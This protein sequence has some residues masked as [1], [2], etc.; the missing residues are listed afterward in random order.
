MTY[1]ISFKNTITQLM[2]I[3]IIFGYYMVIIWSNYHENQT[4]HYQN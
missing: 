2:A 4:Y 3:Y 1:L